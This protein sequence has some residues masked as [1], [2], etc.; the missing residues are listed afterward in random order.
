MSPG[1]RGTRRLPV[2]ALNQALTS[3]RPRCPPPARSM[4]SAALLLSFFFFAFSSSS[5]LFFSSSLLLPTSSSLHPN[6]PL[7]LLPFS[8]SVQLPFPPPPPPF[9]GI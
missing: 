6:L 2:K 1:I 9:F 8:S 5:L 4:H 7:F 3:P